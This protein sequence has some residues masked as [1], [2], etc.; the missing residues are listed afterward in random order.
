MTALSMLALLLTHPLE[1]RTLVQFWLYH[2]KNRDLSSPSEFATSGWDRKSMRRC[3]E[4]LD[5]TSRSFSAVIKELDGDLARTICM[6]YLVLR[7]LDTIEDDMT[8]PDD[9]KQ[10]LLRTFHEKTVTPGWTFDGCGPDEKDRQL[11]VEYDVVVEELNRIAPDCREVIVDICHKMEVGMADY[12]HKAATTGSI[13][14]E[15]IAEYELYCH[16]VAGLVG[17]GLSRLFS[18]TGKEADWLQ[19]Q[20]ELSNSMGTLL[21][22]TNIIRDYR[23][24]VEQGRYFWPREIWGREEYGGFKEMNEFYKP[25]NT[26]RA[27]WVQSGMVIDALRHAE[28]ALDYLRLLRNQTVFNFCA[29]PATMAMATLELCFMNPEMFQRNIKIRKAEAARLIMRSTNPREVA[30]M[31]RDYARKIHAKA[32]PSDPNFL[33]LSVACGK[34]EQWCER[35]YPSF[36]NVAQSRGGGNAAQMFDPLDARTR[37][38]KLEQERDRAIAREKR[39]A[40]YLAN[41]KPAPAEPAGA[42]TWELFSFVAA[43][44]LIVLCGALG[45]VWVVL[46]FTQD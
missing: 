44:F 26:E 34:I 37:I 45:V 4:F 10:P 17:E 13:Y 30:Y 39:V 43:A 40:S 31:F 5:L 18:A 29:I 1:F 33:R 27:L 3:W 15:T 9:I 28:D 25:E 23:E 12:A 46:K 19:Y 21:Q 22:K 7:G 41:G 35:H 16:Y 6:F 11:L 2:D 36:V 14:I 24:D 38:V 20:L 8:I 42:S 32:V